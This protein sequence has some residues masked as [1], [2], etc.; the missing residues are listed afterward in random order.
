MPAAQASP[1]HALGELV[2]E[3]PTA[4][5]KGDDF[6]LLN[7][8]GHVIAHIAD[9]V[10]ISA[11]RLC[12]ELT[13]QDCADGGGHCLAITAP[14]LTAN[15]CSEHPANDAAADAWRV[16]LHLNLLTLLLHDRYEIRLTSYH[17]GG[18]QTLSVSQTRD[19]CRAYGNVVPGS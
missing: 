6:P 3:A 10:G 7:L 14:D 1:L 12:A 11:C 2:A 18:V 16:A 17:D 19:A 4:V 13:P 5:F 9:L 15:R 8:H